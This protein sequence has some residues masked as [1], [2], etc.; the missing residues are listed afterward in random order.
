MASSGS[1]HDA[2]RLARLERAPLSA[3]RALAMGAAVSVAFTILIWLLGGWLADVPHAVDAGPSW[4]YV[5]L[6]EPTTA[7]RL[8]A[9]G[10]YLH[11]KS[12]SGR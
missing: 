12:R 6:I 11:T 1:E 8:T 9:W 4:H 7:S 2:R 3:Y 10:C 5:K